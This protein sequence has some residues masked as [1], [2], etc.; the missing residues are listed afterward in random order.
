[1][2][3]FNAVGPQLLRQADSF[4]ESVPGG[5]TT[6]A[7]VVAAVALAALATVASTFLPLSLLGFTG[8][9]VL[10]GLGV[11]AAGVLLF[12]KFAEQLGTALG[13]R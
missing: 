11:A 9:V 8:G 1:M 10:G 6:V 4:F 3:G 12:S 5:R 2:A 13:R 7:V